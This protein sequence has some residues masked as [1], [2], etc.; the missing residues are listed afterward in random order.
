MTLFLG[1]VLLC[2]IYDVIG[3]SGTSR[4][5][6]RYAFSILLALIVAGLMMLSYWGWQP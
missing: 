4:V 2:V 3:A 6:W 5:W 1:F